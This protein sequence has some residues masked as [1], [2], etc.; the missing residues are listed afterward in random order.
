MRGANKLNR[1]FACFRVC[2]CVSGCDCTPNYMHSEPFFVSLIIILQSLSLSSR[3]TQ[4]AQTTMSRGYWWHPYT[5]HTLSVDASFRSHSR[6][7]IRCSL[8]TYNSQR[9][10]VFSFDWFQLTT[11]DSSR[12]RFPFSFGSPLFLSPRRLFAAERLFHIKQIEIYRFALLFLPL[13]L[14]AYISAHSSAC[15]L[16]PISYV[17]RFPSPE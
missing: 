11:I 10:T 15:S 12:W 9:F 13:Y 6:R 5:A 17:Q 8:R 1:L 7:W 2:V 14:C 16:F 4:R 3:R